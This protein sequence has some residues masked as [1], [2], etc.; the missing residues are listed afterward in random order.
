ARRAPSQAPL[1][2]APALARAAFA[3]ASGAAL[4]GASVVS[5]HP[6]VLAQIATAQHNFALTSWASGRQGHVVQPEFG[7]RIFRGQGEGQAVNT[8][9]IEHQSFV[10]DWRF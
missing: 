4:S 9:S 5:L 3:D 2:P 8:P 1:P 6:H 7:G 10:A